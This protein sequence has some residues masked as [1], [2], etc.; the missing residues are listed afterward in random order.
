MDVIEVSGKR[1]YVVDDKRYPSVTTVLSIIRSPALERW[2]G[3]LG[4]VEA[5]RRRDEAAAI[6]TK[7]HQ[8]CALFNGNTKRMFDI[9]D[10]QLRAM[11]D[12]YCAWFY[13]AVERVVATEIPVFN[14][15]YGYA[16]TIDLI[17]VLKGDHSPSVIDLKTTNGFWPD[18]PLQLAAYRE[19]WYEHE[20]YSECYPSSQAAIAQPCRRLVVR[21][22]KVIQGK[23]EVREYTEHA[24]DFNAFVCALGLFKYFDS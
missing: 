4:N 19:A 20:M 24:K 11:F 23:V 9:S 7:L 12:A 8:L 5:D 17:A 1:Y 16:G 13:T 21:I 2:R 10:D 3:E 15:V 18:Q 22:D 6:G 14:R